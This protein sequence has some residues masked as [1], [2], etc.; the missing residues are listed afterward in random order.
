MIELHLVMIDINQYGSSLVYCRSILIFKIELRSILNRML[1]EIRHDQYWFLIEIVIKSILIITYIRSHFIP[2][3]S[4]LNTI[5]SYASIN[6]DQYWSILI[7]INVDFRDANLMINIDKYWSISIRFNNGK[8]GILP[9]KIRGDK[10][11]SSVHRLIS[12]NIDRYLS[13]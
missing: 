5:I 12:I 2:H 8:I 10:D 13:A 9:E 1:I 3:R 4:T 6:T 11:I 7:S